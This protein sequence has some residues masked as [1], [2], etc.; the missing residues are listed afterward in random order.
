MEKSLKN[1]KSEILDKAV[2]LMWR[3]WS[4]LGVAGYETIKDSFVIDPEAL[5]LFSSTFARHDARLFDEMLDWLNVNGAFLN[6]QRLQNI[7][8]QY[9]LGDKR[10]IGAISAILS[11]RSAN[12]LKWKKL[13][14]P[15]PFDKSEHLFIMP[16]RRPLPL[17]GKSNPVFEKYG[18]KR[19][20]INTRG[21]SKPFSQHGANT[22]LLRLRALFGVS[23]RCET[24]AL[25][26]ASGEINPSEAARRA[27]YYQRTIQNVLVEM[28]FSGAVIVRRDKKEKKYSLASGML[29]AILTPNGKKPVWIN[30]AAFFKGLEIILSGLLNLQ[31]DENDSLLI[32]SELRQLMIKASPFFEETGMNRLLS[33]HASYK[34]ESYTPIFFSDIEKIF[35]E[36]NI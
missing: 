24:L 35:K 28:V 9:Q 23:A 16:D 10:V 2:N 29:D 30:W 27:G 1:Y 4:S 19:G 25:L 31:L 32:S 33:N 11:G 8:K 5:L 13:V 20:E 12:T 26:A 15:L 21:Y 36:V 6:I 14:S 34:G 22:L 18:L 3:Q 17:T 7:A